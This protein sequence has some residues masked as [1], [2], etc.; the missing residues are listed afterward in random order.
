[1]I[2]DVDVKKQEQG[3]E[4]L[5]DPPKRLMGV[6]AA[7]D[8]ITSVTVP[9]TVVMID[10]TEHREERLKVDPQHSYRHNIRQHLPHSIS[11]VLLFLLLLRCGCYVMFSGMKVALDY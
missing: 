1:V 5:N 7:V 3:G 8:Q 4:A 2:D 9:T 6:A 10:R 11:H